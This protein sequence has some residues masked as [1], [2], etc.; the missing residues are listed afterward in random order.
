MD[1]LAKQKGFRYA[2]LVSKKQLLAEKREEILKLARQHGVDSIKVFGS[3]ARG[4]D[5]ESSDI[6]FLVSVEEGRSL[7]DTGRLLMDLEELLGCRVDLLSERGLRDRF[8]E[9]VRREASLL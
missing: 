9:R 4:E 7:F 5:T 6:D 1:S 3:V 2:H 8:K